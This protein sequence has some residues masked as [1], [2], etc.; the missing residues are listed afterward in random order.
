M[1]RFAIA[2]NADCCGNGPELRQKVTGKEF[3]FNT[4]FA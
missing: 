1:D 3:Y 4:E 2:L